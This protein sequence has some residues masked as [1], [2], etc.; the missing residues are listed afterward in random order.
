[1][2]GMSL[3]F[4]TSSPRP[5]LFLRW[6]R[7]CSNPRAMLAKYSKTFGAFCRVKQDEMSSFCLNNRFRLPENKQ[8]YQSQEITSKNAISS[9]VT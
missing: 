5:F 2:N 4:A 8:G 1:M 7:G 6:R 9:C 3:L